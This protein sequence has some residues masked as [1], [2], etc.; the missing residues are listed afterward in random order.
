MIHIFAYEQYLKTVKNLE[1][2]EKLLL[3]DKYENRLI[4]Y[5]FREGIRFV[6]HPWRD[7]HMLVIDEEEVSGKVKAQLLLLPTR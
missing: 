5:L 1:F 2:G 6:P 7:I 3:L 4:L